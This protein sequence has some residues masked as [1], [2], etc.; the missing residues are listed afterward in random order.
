MLAG[1]SS[2]LNRKERLL[3]TNEENER[4][5]TANPDDF[6]NIVNSIFVLPVGLPL[7]L[8]LDIAKS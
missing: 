5:P 8:A 2:C 3:D 6:L 4:W 1:T 7:S